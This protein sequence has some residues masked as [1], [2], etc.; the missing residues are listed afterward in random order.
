MQMRIEVPRRRACTQQVGA[1]E[2]NLQEVT[3]VM[4]PQTS[5]RGRKLR[6]SFTARDPQL[7]RDELKILEYLAVSTARLH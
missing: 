5:N 7:R 4:C 6:S 3:W 1:F 2:R